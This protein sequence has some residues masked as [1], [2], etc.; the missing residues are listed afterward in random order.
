[1]RYDEFIANVRRLGEYES[2]ERAEQVTQRVLGV[3]GARITA[4]E[5]ED[6]AAQLP[7]DLAGA[8]RSE[9]RSMPNLSPDEFAG[10]VAARLD[11][12]STETARWD[13]SAVLTTVTESIDGGEL[14]HVLSQLPSGFAT[15]FGHPELA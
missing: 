3:L 4:D 11:G 13:V 14:N 8:L 15:F 2:T 9:G 6:L 5:A 1:M 10:A 12:A 7:G